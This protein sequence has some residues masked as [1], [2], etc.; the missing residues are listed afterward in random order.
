M[1]PKQCGDSEAVPGVDRS[2]PSRGA[3]DTNPS[4][5][6]IFM[7]YELQARCTA[8]FGCTGDFAAC[9]FVWMLQAPRNSRKALGLI[10]SRVSAMP[11]DAKIRHARL[12]V[13]LGLIV[14]VA[15]PSSSKHVSGSGFDDDMLKQKR[16]GLRTLTVAQ[17]I[18]SARVLVASSWY[19]QVGRRLAMNRSITHCFLPAAATC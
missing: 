12:Q 5:D 8:L 10:F 9:D 2:Q 17:K 18:C 4:F 7:P 11:G 3:T 1:I 15:S 6:T 13:Q 19:C 14:P 16:A